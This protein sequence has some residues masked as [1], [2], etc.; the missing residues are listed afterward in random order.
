VVRANETPQQ[1][2]L[3]ALEK[4]DPAKAIGCVLNQSWAASGL[5]ASYGDGYYGY[6]DA[7]SDA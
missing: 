3:A 5:A 1:A 2:V 4:L 7:P 6:G